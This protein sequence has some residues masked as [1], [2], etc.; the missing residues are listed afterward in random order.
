M[1]EYV[2]TK[3]NKWK[4]FS[5]EEILVFSSLL[6]ANLL[7]IYYFLGNFILDFNGYIINENYLINGSNLF[8]LQQIYQ[9]LVLSS[10]FSLLIPIN[11]YL[12]F[13][14]LYKKVKA[15]NDNYS[16][17]QLFGRFFAVNVVLFAVFM[18]IF[19]LGDYSTQI[20]YYRNFDYYNASYGFITTSVFSP[21]ISIVILAL[22]VLCIGIL[23][24]IAN[25]LTN[26][27]NGRS[28]FTEYKSFWVIFEENF[29]LFYLCNVIMM[30][31]IIR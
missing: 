4:I 28:N 29:F 10:V 18:T 25:E 6:L 16:I 2:D 13:I 31:I 9:F 30:N 19:I 3:T 21:I 12:I 8:F 5:F 17:F 1:S 27:K 23:I 20:G 22:I 14:P 11:I 24:F 15:K 7:I 26:L